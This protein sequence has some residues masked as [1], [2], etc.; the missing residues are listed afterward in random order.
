MAGRVLPR[1]PGG[2]EV[3]ATMIISLDTETTGVDLRH[4]CKPFFVSTCDD[5]GTVRCWEWDVDPYTRDV[6]VPDGGLDEIRDLLDRAD[7]VVLHNT[8]FDAAALAAVGIKDFPWGKVR[9]TLLGAHLLAS[10][11]PKD[12][13]SL[14]LQYLG[15]DILPHEAALGEAVKAARRWCRSNRPDWQVAREG[16]PH[17]PS[18]KG[19][20][21]R[22][23]YWLPRTVFYGVTRDES[24]GLPT[25]WGTVL[26]DYASADAE[27]TLPLWFRMER[28]V[29]RRGLWKIYEERLKLLPIG[30]EMEDRGVTLSRS[31]L[32]ES[33]EMYREES[34]AKGRV[35]VNLARDCGFDLELPRN[36]INQSLRTFCFDVLN[37][38]PIRNPKAMTDAPTLNKAAVER[39]LTTLRPNSREHAFVKALVEK[40]SRDTAV[41]YMEGY[42]RFWKPLYRVP[43]KVAAMAEALT[44]NPFETTMSYMLLG[45]IE[46]ERE[47]MNAAVEWHV[48]HPNLNPTGTDTLRWSSSS[49]NE[50]NIS[51]KENFNLRYCFGPP[52]GYEWWSLDAKNIELR[53]PFYLAGEKELIELFE[54][55]DKP[56]YYGS[57]HLL[58]FHT[59]YPEIWEREL[60]EVGI[61]KVGPHCKKKY[62]ST[63]YQRCKNGGFC[64]QYGGQERLTDATFGREGCY[65]LIKSR[66]AKLEALNQS[67]IRFANSHGYVE[68]IPDRT[69]DPT[70]GYPL[71]C[72]RTDSGGV[73]PTVPL[74]FKIQGSAM[75]WTGKAMTRTQE[76][77]IREW[78]RKDFDARIVMQVHDECVFQLP[79]RAD[80]RE[81]PKRSNL[82][83]VRE[84]AREMERGGHEDYGIPT[85]VG[86]EYHPDNWSEGVTF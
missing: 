80:P 5:A 18:V 33:T 79:R 86:I 34:E 28:E 38:P 85:P 64:M 67:C 71:L 2:P 26:F 30:Y 57:N 31:R 29:N 39:Y 49:P 69:V 21:W 82:G 13:T 20:A 41:Q 19:E 36:G 61:E 62:A 53:L 1:P 3:G 14:A 4:G 52:P 56:P 45:A 74:S 51:K 55:P 65:R 70:R 27:Y 59:A 58:N 6:A 17:L 11:R 73:L 47:G 75:W 24:S 84:L 8:K 42:R 68:T 77:P 32:E 15:E 25:R 44:E 76:G 60:K 54:E 78:R 22:C 37:L 63:W 48:L 7:L 72:T 43:V 35:C 9:D 10:N 81:D 40:R 23:D 16:H 66:F 50:Q 83:R 46:D 12:L